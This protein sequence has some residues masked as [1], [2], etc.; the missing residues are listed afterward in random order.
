M[1][2]DEAG[3]VLVLL[4][5]SRMSYAALKAAAEIAGSTGA[6]VLGVVVEEMNLLRSG[7]VGFWSV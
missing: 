2:S 1:S 4:D 7:G 3:R 6:D 5:G